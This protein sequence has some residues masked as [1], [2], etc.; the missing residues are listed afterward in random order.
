[1]CQKHIAT[2]MR[3]IFQF[4]SNGQVTQ[5]FWMILIIRD[6]I[7]HMEKPKPPTNYHVYKIKLE[8]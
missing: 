3:N 5:S 8:T 4:F 6:K 1:M 2:E 7:S